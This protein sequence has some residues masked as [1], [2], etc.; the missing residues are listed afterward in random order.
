MDSFPSAEL[1]ERAW[2]GPKT[3]STNPETANKPG[4]FE[5][6]VFF[7][8]NIGA[9]TSLFGFKAYNEI[10]FFRVEFHLFLV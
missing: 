7:D 10:T 1:E 5:V 4:C 6:N 3:P 9:Q 8:F 2:P